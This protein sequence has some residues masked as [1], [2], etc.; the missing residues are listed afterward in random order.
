MAGYFVTERLDAEEIKNQMYMK[1]LTHFPRLWSS[2][3]KKLGFY[4]W[5]EHPAEDAI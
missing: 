3:Y 4:F 5:K 1:A 2:I